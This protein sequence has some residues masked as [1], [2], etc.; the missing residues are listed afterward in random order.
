MNNVQSEEQEFNYGSYSVKPHLYEENV[1]V[2]SMIM[3][4]TSV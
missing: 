3:C 1:K 2:K 4:Q